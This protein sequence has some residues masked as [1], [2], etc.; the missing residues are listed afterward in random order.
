MPFVRVLCI[1]KISAHAPEQAR[2]INKLLAPIEL[3]SQELAIRLLPVS[4]FSK[5]TVSFRRRLD[6]WLGAMA[7]S[8]LPSSRLD[9]I[10]MAHLHQLQAL[11]KAASLHAASHINAHHVSAN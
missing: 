8:K 1:K 9:L 5:H 6:M 2:V 4:R 11:R 10:Q 7:T 3:V